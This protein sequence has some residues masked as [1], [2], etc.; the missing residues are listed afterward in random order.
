MLVK[1]GSPNCQSIPTVGCGLQPSVLGGRTDRSSPAHTSDRVS[2]NTRPRPT[3][4]WRGQ[5]HCQRWPDTYGE[6]ANCDQADASPPPPGAASPQRSSSRDVSSPA[7][8]GQRRRAP[9]L[10]PAKRRNVVRPAGQRDPAQPLR[11]E[12]SKR[13]PTRTRLSR[14]RLSKDGGIGKLRWRSRW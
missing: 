3:F 10:I 1:K 11:R 13:S 4:E 7:R 8:T 14:F 6:L 12:T 5:D 2:T 9:T